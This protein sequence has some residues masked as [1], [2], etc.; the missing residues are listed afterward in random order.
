MTGKE[1]IDARMLKLN[2]NKL[3]NRT[4][5]IKISTVLYTSFNLAS[6]LI[7]LTTITFH[8]PTNP[9][10]SPS[11]SV[12]AP[13]LQLPQPRPSL[14]ALPRHHTRLLKV[15]ERRML[16]TPLR[17]INRPLMMRHGMSRWS[18]GDSSTEREILPC[19]SEMTDNHERGCGDAGGK[20]VVVGF[21]Q[22]DM[23]ESRLGVE[24]TLPSRLRISMQV[25]SGSTDMTSVMVTLG[26]EGS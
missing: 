8:F 22:D 25:E 9:P 5:E 26:R 2:A 7:F 14:P 19:G 24:V 21:G 15:R 17:T 4:P 1:S 12:Q 6:I 18:I 3:K 11:P 10:L 16:K 23:D 20:G 13:S